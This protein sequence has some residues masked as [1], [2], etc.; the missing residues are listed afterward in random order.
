MIQLTVKSK[1]KLVER[2]RERGREREGERERERERGWHTTEFP[3]LKQTSNMARVIRGQSDP[4][5]QDISLWWKA[6]QNENN[7][8]KVA[9]KSCRT[10]LSLTLTIF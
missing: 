3:G 7:V 4:D 5:R 6:D 9:S 1:W 2:E 10:E 8:G